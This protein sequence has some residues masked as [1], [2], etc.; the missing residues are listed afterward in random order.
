MGGM[1]GSSPL[2]AFML[3]GVPAVPTP[4]TFNP[5]WVDDDIVINEVP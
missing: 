5:A 2:A 1:L 4:S 3:A